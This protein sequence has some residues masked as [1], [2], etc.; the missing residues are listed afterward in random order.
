VS[1]KLEHM[2]FLSL[3]VAVTLLFGLLLWPFLAPLLFLGR[4][5][6]GAVPPGTGLAFPALG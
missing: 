5:H 2:A 6:R 4:D 3:L 1:E